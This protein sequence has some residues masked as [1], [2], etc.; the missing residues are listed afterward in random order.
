ME[1]L[2]EGSVARHVVLYAKN[3]YAETEVIADLRTIISMVCGLTLEQI[4]ID[5]VYELVC[6]TFNQVVEG[7]YKDNF[8][9]KL[10]DW[11]TN[12]EITRLKMISEMLG[13]ISAVVCMDR[14]GNDILGMGEPDVN[15]LPLKTNN[16]EVG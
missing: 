13:Y 10:F 15:V 16:W 1:K 8:I 3:H 11:E 12:G 9:L 5:V 2:R 7:I 14:D 4:S 6:K